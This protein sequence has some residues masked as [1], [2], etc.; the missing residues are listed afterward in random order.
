MSRS[1]GRLYSFILFIVLALF[2]LSVKQYKEVLT[3]EQEYRDRVYNL[4]P[5]PGY[6]VI[7]ADSIIDCKG[8]RIRKPWQLPK[9]TP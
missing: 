9:R 4:D 3:R 8:N 2:L 5:C 6:T 1:T 7:N